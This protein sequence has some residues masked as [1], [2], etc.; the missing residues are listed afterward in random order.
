MTRAVLAVGS[1]LGDRF[2]ELT[3]AVR[4]L[5]DVLLV[6]SGVYETPPW[7]DPDQPS[8]LNAAVL[9][10]RAGRSGGVAHPGTVPG[11]WGESGT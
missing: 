11:E 7:G 5:S 2:G 3:R 10:R 6:V 9:G 8:Y 4:A 1:N